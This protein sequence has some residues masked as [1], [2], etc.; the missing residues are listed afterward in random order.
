[1]SEKFD[2]TKFDRPK[3]K[4]AGFENLPPPPGEETKTDAAVP[5]ARTTPPAKKPEPS[6]DESGSRARLYFR[7]TQ[8]YA[9]RFEAICREHFPRETKISVFERMIEIAETQLSSSDLKSGR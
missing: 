9:D 8:E 5:A 4:P 2:M 6:A 1:M 3:P 7:C